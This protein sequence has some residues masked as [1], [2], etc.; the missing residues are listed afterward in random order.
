MNIIVYSMN[1]PMQLEACLRSMKLLYKEYEQSKVTVIFKSTDRKYLDGYRTLYGTYPEV[2]FV[3]ETVFKTNTMNALDPKNQFTMF[4]S[5]D[6]I[7]KNNFSIND[8]TPFKIMASYGPK[9]V[10][11]VSIR[12]HKGISYCYASDKSSK[13]PNFARDIPNEACVWS[14]PGC[15][16]DWG[17]PYSLECN[18][19]F[20]DYITQYLLHLDFYNPNTMESNM[21]LVNQTVLPKYM[22]CYPNKAKVINV[23]ANRVQ[24]TF[25]QNRYENSFS[26][27]ELNKMFLEGKRISLENV[28][29]IDSNAVHYPID[30]KFM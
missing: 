25:L 28:L 15:E 14:Y 20:T 11:T 23:P 7:F 22:V 29:D 10:L 1:R 6:N 13:L 4:V 26:E 16:G 2:N 8:D 27:E 21:N 18:T 19:F 12:L 5:D 17:Y 24:T 9:H 3:Q 30:F